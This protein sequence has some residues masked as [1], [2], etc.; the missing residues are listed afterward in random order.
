VAAALGGAAG[1][2]VF[3]PVTKV[4]GSV[5]GESP[6]A[7]LTI[8]GLLVSGMLLGAGVGRWL[9]LR[10]VSSRPRLLLLS[11]TLGTIGGVTMGVAVLTALR[12]VAGPAPTV[13]LAVLCGL[14][15]FGFTQWLTLRRHLAWGAKWALVS[16]AGLTIALLGVGAFTFFFVHLIGGVLAAQLGQVGVALFRAVQGLVVGSLYGSVTG[17]L[18]MEP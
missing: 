18:R 4:V 1:G 10:R 12:G 2:G 14:G 16:G 5:I 8:W 7:L 11:E 9:V 3:D 13:A 17:R 15:A 6:V